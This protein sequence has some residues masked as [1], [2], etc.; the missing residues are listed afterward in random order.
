MKNLLFA[1]FAGSVCCC[2]AQQNAAPAPEPEI[3]AT[4]PSDAGRGLIRVNSREIRI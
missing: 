2:Y 3:V 4:P 1:L